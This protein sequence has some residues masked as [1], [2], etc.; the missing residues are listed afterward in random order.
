MLRPMPCMEN[1]PLF[2]MTVT[3]G[4]SDH[5]FYVST[6]YA[7]HNIANYYDISVD[8]NANAYQGFVRNQYFKGF[9]HHDKRTAPAEQLKPSY[10]IHA[11]LTAAGFSLDF[12]PDGSG[13]DGPLNEFQMQLIADTSSS[14]RSLILRVL[15]AL[16]YILRYNYSLGLTGAIELVDILSKEQPENILIENDFEMLSVSYNTNNQTTNFSFENPDMVRG[17][18]T[19]DGVDAIEERGKLFVFGD[20]PFLQTDVTAVQYGT[21]TCRYQDVSSALGERQDRYRFRIP[22]EAYYGGINGE[23]LDIQIGDWVALDSIEVPTVSDYVAVQIIEKNNAED[24][25]TFLGVSRV[26]SE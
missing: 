2:S 25:I 10:F 5:A 3:P 26:A 22:A 1:H 24:Y 12:K 23:F 18:A 19:L 11:V 20:T 6:R 15:P 13:V 17:L 14:Y 9:Y 21:W 4:D 7:P 8:F 16:G